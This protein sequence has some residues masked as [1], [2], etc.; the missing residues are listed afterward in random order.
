MNFSL[1]L[2]GTPSNYNQY[3]ADTNSQLFQG[4]YQIQKSDSQLTIYRSGQLVYYT[5]TRKLSSG[6]SSNYLGICLIFNG[7]YCRDNKQF[8][9]IFDKAYSDIALNGK[10]LLIDKS[11]NISF[12]TDKFANKELE[13]ERIKLF[14]QNN[15]KYFRKDFALLT[16]SFRVGNGTK[17]LSVNDESITI[18]EA[19]RL[20][21]CVHLTNNEKSDSE[22]DRIH[23]M[24]SNLYT[25]KRE[26]NTK[27]IRL[28][29]QKKQYKVVM[30]LC[31]AILGCILVLIIF[32]RNL[33]SKDSKI[34]SLETELTEKND[35]IS[36]QRSNI[37]QLQVTKSKLNSE[38]YNLKETLKQKN[39]IIDE[40]ISDILNLNY[41]NTR[42][43]LANKSLSN[44]LN[45][46]KD[47]NQIISSEIA[48]C[49][50]LGPK[51]YQV[52]ASQ[53]DCYRQCAGKY[54]KNDCYYSSGAIVDV[55][56]QQDGYGL[57]IGGYLKMNELQK[58]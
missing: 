9:D 3:P 39:S 12:A 47:Q 13:I 54:Y 36:H 29:R 46:F 42:L 51:K 49:K 50:S 17:A 1:Y 52:L 43:N 20:Y 2:F 14:F 22:L 4:F 35:S 24:L 16:S 56:T 58:Y 40:Q 25:E 41:Q 37:A 33:Q 55:Y 34:L 19:I 27:Y 44:D 15:L 30:L 38:I 48:N 45:D 10:I 18:L 26:L 28:L 31:I 5:F 11:G 57:T 8:F 6:S 53:S 32:N 23:K 21:D 7:I